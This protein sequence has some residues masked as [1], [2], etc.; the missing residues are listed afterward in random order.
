VAVDQDPMRYGNPVIATPDSADSGAEADGELLS[1]FGAL[2]ALQRVTS[3]I[4]STLDL[5]TILRVVLDEAVRFTA[6]DAGLVVLFPQQGAELRAW[7]G[8]DDEALVA[9]TAALAEPEDESPLLQQ[10]SRLETVYIPHADSTPAAACLPS[11]VSLLVV[12]VFHEQLLAAAILIQST[13]ADRFGVTTIEFC[14]SLAGQASIA[15]G[16]ARR[17]REQMLRGEQMRRRAEQMSLLLEISRMMRS[18]RPLD[19]I[20]AD[21]AYAVQ[22]GTGFDIVLISI[23]EDNFLRHA[24]AAGIS[25]VEFEE[26]RTVRLRWD[27]VRRLCEERFRLGRCY[28]IPERHRDLTQD[29]AFHM[30]EAALPGG[31]ETSW[32]AE[33]TY[34]VLLRS[35]GGDVLGVMSLDQ[36]RD[37][38]APTS[39][40][41]E[42]VELF[43]SQVAQMIETHRLVE[44]LQR[45]VT[46]LQLFNELNRSITTN[47]DLPVVLNTVVQSVTNLLGYDFS[48]I[49]L[50]GQNEE[51]FVPLASSGYALDLLTDTLLGAGAGLVRDV[52]RTGMPL[53][54]DDASADPRFDTTRV[55]VG[56]SIVVPLMVEGRS[57]GI[58]TADRKMLGEFSPADVAAL[59]ALAD[60]VTVA[61]ENARLFEEV[62][63]FNEELEARVAERTQELADALEGLRIQ[64]DRSEVLYHIASEL[65]ASLD[66]DQVL[67]QALLLLQR[68]VKASRS[69]VILLDSSTGQLV[70]RA[71]IGR[72]QPIPPGGMP[73]PFA[74]DRGV[75]GWVLR[76][77]E[78]LVLPDVQRSDEFYSDTMSGIRSVMAVPV[79]DGAGESLGVLLFESPIVDVF[80]ETQLRLVEAAAVQLGNALNNAELYGMIR[81]QAERLGAMLRTQQIDA[82]KNQAI[83]EG[84]ADGV[85][86]AD[87]PGRVILFNA[88]AE[89]ILSITREQTVGRSLEEIL[90]LYSSEVHEWLSQIEQWR[91]DPD[92]YGLGAFLSHRLEVGRRFVSVHLSPVTAVTGE[93]LGVV[94]VFRDITPEIEADRAKSDFVSTVSHELRTPMTSIVGYVDLMVSGAVGQLPEMQLSFLKKV[95]TNADRLTNLVNDLLDISRIEQGRVELLRRPISM[96]KLVTQVEDLVR[97][98]V[99]EKSQ[100]WRTIVPADLPKVYGDPDR[101]TQILTN[102]VSNAYKYTP[103]GGRITVQAYVREGMMRVAVVD[104]GIGIAPENQKKI[105][106][107][108]YRVEGDPAVYEVSGTGL[109]LAISLSLIQMHEGSIWL[110]SEL[111]QGSIFTF[112]VPL[113]E[114]EPTQDVGEPPEPLVVTS[115]PT[116]LVVEDDQ[117]ISTMLVI[118]LESEGF[119]V[120]SASS[121]EEA[122][123]IARQKLP[124]FIS[125]DIRL[126][127]LDGFEVLQLLKREPETADIPVV[128][129][130]VVP[131]RERG[132]M[133]GALDFLSKPLDA[134]QLLAVINR[135]LAQGEI[136]LIAHSDRDV[137]NRLRTMLQLKGLSVRTT[138]RGDRVLRLVRDI[139]PRVVVID[140]RLPDIDGIQMLDALRRDRRTAEI[141]VVVTVKPEE[142]GENGAQRAWNLDRVLFVSDS[143]SVEALLDGISAVGGEHSDDKESAYGQDP[144]R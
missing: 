29:M 42:V 144:G 122:L 76:Q 9:I 12:P 51:H 110:E 19:K 33:D 69:S 143:S 50:R 58:L 2:V 32:H 95:K 131:D 130:S 142:F 3:E 111:G 137:V 90:G 10:L 60:Q 24:A 65:V 36:P 133:L 99:L 68:A 132:H 22:E 134:A 1:R 35:S 54:V 25:V 124:D 86:F 83:L 139:R 96:L 21:V 40:T 20:L 127:D 28:Y 112:S 59:M 39:M 119:Y 104:T 72:T 45:Q 64:R 37:G 120:L 55:P 11:A 15:I 67:S 93:F 85:M 48:T 30:S 97:P 129:V 75:V 73:A 114:G 77:R 128:I 94:S 101:L 121:G 44:N 116:I 27:R 106:E 7:Q 23:L 102:L 118:A 80:D 138:M 125:L 70:F 6:A 5:D 49:Y 62:K 126:P 105:F 87:A 91:H 71:A 38:L 107:R 34:F 14:K 108:F 98:K 81:E 141:P 18:D 63:R 8:Y 47:L 57:V 92:A 4:N 136:I 41:S 84:I 61:V 115:A 53:V 66:M 140:P 74:R 52:V 78:A 16:N 43:A 100:I 26:R 88:A 109:G 123:R 13:A 46:T 135:T 82:A 56:S 113:A 117:E 103:I 79:V 17:Y 31:D 89:R